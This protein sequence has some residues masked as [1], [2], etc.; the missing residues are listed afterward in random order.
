MALILYNGS[1]KYTSP[2]VASAM[3]NSIPAITFFLA[4]LMKMEVIKFRSSSGMAKTAGIALCLAGVLV[5]ALYAGRSLSPLGRHRV[6]A[7]HGDRQAAEHVSKGVWITGT[8]V[9]LLVCVAWSLWMVFQV[10]DNKDGHRSV[11]LNC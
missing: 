7:G 5:M 6:L 4:L 10:D 1:L 11:T 9:M 8:F 3:A 2:T